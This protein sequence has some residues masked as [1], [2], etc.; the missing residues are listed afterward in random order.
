LFSER[1]IYPT[2]HGIPLAIAVVTIEI[3]PGYIKGD[4]S[5]FLFLQVKIPCQ[6]CCNCTCPA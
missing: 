3:S 4:F 1:D 2:L 5:G 6:G